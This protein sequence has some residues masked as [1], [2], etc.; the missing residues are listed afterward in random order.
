M[1]R[2]VIEVAQR[3]R[4]G[5]GGRSAA[6]FL[7]GAAHGLGISQAAEGVAPAGSMPAVET[8]FLRV[9]C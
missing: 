9:N 5:Y 4:R 1:R 3:I 7:E 6:A 8:A 2:D